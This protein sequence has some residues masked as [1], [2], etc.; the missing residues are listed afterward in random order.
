MSTIRYRVCAEPAAH[1]YLVTAQFDSPGNAPVLRLPNWIR[2]SYLVRDFAK[3]VQGL[4]AFV[5]DRPVTITRFDKG[6]FRVEGQGRIRLEY[7]VHA[8]D[9]SVRKAYLDTR[10]GFFNGSSLFYCPAGAES[11]G[12]DVVI[13]RPDPSLCPGWKLATALVPVEIA[14]DGF[15][16]YR[17]D[18]YEE[19]IDCPVE[20]AAYQSI[21]FD[22]DGIPHS[23]VL[24][25]RCEPDLPRLAADIARVC[26]VQ[27]E[28]FGQQP[29]KAQMAQ[30]LFLTQVTGNGYGGLEHRTSTALVTARDALPRPGQT[31]LRKGYRGFLGLVSH[32]YFH[33][34]NVKRITAARFAD[35]DLSAEAY[36]EDLWAYEGVTSYY[37]DL[38]L[39]RAGLIDAPVYLDLLAEAATRLQ[40]TP[41]RTVQTLADASFEAWIKYYQP[42]ENTP[43]AAV[44][45][46]VKGALATLCLDLWLRLHSSV[47]MDDVMRAL[48]SRY[49]AH[50]IGVPE[51]GL[52][53]VASEISGL[54]LTVQ[55]D[56]W[57][58]GTSEL[59][60]AELLSQ[61]GVTAAL[62]LSHGASDE[63]GRSESR[64]Y[65]ATTLGLN[66]RA[67]ETTVAT[68]FS[69]SP[70]ESAGLAA[71]DQLIAFDGLKLTAGNWANR[72]EALYAGV[73]VPLSLF[74]GDELMTV[75]IEPTAPVFDTWTFTLA[76]ANG[77]VLDRRIAWLGA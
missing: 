77:A 52:E 76:E 68:V 50:D 55:F 30:Y 64:S 37:D 19:L 39:L 31:G 44:N 15:G 74:R 23:L 4:K 12:F 33:L 59:P 56:L 73:A 41:G 5:D 21:V 9:S 58:R 6:R 7:V 57:L 14:D 17:A 71:G 27:R 38:M 53:A 65:P 47:T 69:G 42:D 35:N 2:G 72:L 25:G 1:R 32:E 34:W 18:S 22:V 66:L 36:S 10:R 54:D 20:M 46:Y 40:R 45:Y 11:G 70:A 8:L 75:M 24:S 43:N 61:F 13:E 16:R 3:H 67:G 48:W 62:R 29:Q 26:H 60:L 63:G 51:G 28:L 49:G